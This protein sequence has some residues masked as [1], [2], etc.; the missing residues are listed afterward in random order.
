VAHLTF[1]IPLLFPG[2]SMRR[3]FL[4]APAALLLPALLT[5]QPASIVYRLGQDTVAI[6][7]FT[8]TATRFSGDVVQRS[9]AAIVRLQYEFTTNASGAVTAATVKR[10]QADGT[11]PPGAPSA[12]RFTFTKDSILREVVFA[13]STQ[14]R[15]FAASGGFVNGPTFM[16]AP[17]ELLVAQRRSGRRIDSLPALGQGGSPVVYGLEAVD[18]GQLR[19]RGSGYA[20][21]L[22]FDAAG[23]LQ[24][25]DG[26]FTTNKVIG[27]RVD[28]AMDIAAI[29]R[30]MKPT[31]ILSPRDVARAGFG[32]GGIVLVDYGRPSVRNRTVWGGTLVPFDSVWRAGANDA[33]HLMTTRTL[34]MGDLQV[35]PG[36]Y[37]LWVQHTR[38]GTFL[39]VNKGTGI[40]GTQYDPSKDLGRVAITMSAAPNFVE[41][42]TMAVVAQGGDR[43][44]L[45]L[46][47]GDQA[48]SVPFRVTVPR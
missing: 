7:S 12:A 22:R 24:Q 48:G 27:T 33:T 21:L 29:A 46:S 10:L 45:Q 18:G 36:M 35:P 47:W 30:T 37:T 1:G 13:D 23:K 26:S 34:V 15:A 41:E 43:G 44:A 31:G 4:L 3:R 17:L 11:V 9:G 28:K 19:L 20:M 14:R 5:A 40:W 38:A 25:V 6:E 32:P 8:R 16:Y 39:V 42:Y 2:P